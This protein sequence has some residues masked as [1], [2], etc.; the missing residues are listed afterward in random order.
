MEA[1]NL[2]NGRTLTMKTT[3]RILSTATNLNISRD[4]YIAPF[5][6]QT[7]HSII[8]SSLS[9]LIVATTVIAT[10]KWLTLSGCLE[11]RSK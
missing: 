1:K 11:A 9:V 2:P 3:T 4:I 8:K 10:L 7:T 5:V 6:T